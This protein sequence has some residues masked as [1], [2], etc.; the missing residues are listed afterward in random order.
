MT[1]RLSCLQHPEI[2]RFTDYSHVPSVKDLGRNREPIACR[3]AGKN[4]KQIVE[5]MLE[6]I[7]GL[8]GY[9]PIISNFLSFLKKTQERGVPVSSGSIGGKD[10]RNSGTAFI[11]TVMVVQAQVQDQGRII[12]NI[13]LVPSL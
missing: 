7:T 11:Y 12:E 5:I 6:K 8:H 13:L 1:Q 4:E 10:I 9:D 2:P 3:I